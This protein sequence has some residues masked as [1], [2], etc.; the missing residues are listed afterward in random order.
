MINRRNAIKHIFFIAG[1]MVALPSCFYSPDAELVLKNIKI[2]KAEEDLLI[3]FC[4]TIIPKSL[5]PG[6]KDLGI[7]AFV[8]KML[9]DCYDAEVQ[10]NF[11]EGLA[12][13]KYL[14]KLNF[15]HS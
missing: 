2:L 11:Q 10:A 15:N 5:T 4:E 3:E 7:P 8:L 9:D 14:A 1:S 12:Q 6:A 13:V